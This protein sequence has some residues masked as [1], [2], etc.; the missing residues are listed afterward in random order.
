MSQHSPEGSDLEPEH[1]FS[2]DLSRREVRSLI[3]HLLYA[4]EG[5]DYSVSLESIV[6]MFNRGFSLHIPTDGEIFL[7]SQAVIDARNE[8]DEAIKPLLANWRL[9]RVGLCT[10]LVLR[11]S[12]WELQNVDT[13]SSIVINEAIE[14]SKCF[15]E[16]DAYRFVNGVLDEFCKEG[17]EE[18]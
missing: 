14:L 12:I 1:L 9:E 6:D 8:L 3:F 18:E 15:S 7:T 5:F 4:M 16:K 11:M 2:E 13:A 17:E 10:K